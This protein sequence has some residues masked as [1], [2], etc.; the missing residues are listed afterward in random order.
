MPKPPRRSAS[1]NRRCPGACI[2]CGVGWREGPAMAAENDRP[3]A[4]PEPPPVSDTAREAAVAA[5]LRRFDEKISEPRQGS[6][7]VVR[8]MEQTAK[9]TLPSPRRSV[10]LQARYGIAASL[11]FLLVA[12]L[13]WLYLNQLPGWR[14]SD[15]TPPKPQVASAPAQPGDLLLADQKAPVPTPAPPPAPPLAKTTTA[16]ASLASQ[17]L[18][19]AATAPSQEAAFGRAS[20]DSDLRPPSEPVGRD[21]FAGA[22]DN[23]FRIVS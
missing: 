2:R 20:T 11:A 3:A 21:Q 1:R 7:R 10:M 4:L 23:P 8:L 9:S 17:P 19:S 22:P 6:E 16:P 15:L 18:Q 14:P 5:A 13:A 12:S